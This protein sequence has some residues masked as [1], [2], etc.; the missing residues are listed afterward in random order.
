MSCLSWRYGKGRFAAEVEGNG[1][2]EKSTTESMP[3]RSAMNASLRND[4]SLAYYKIVGSLSNMLAKAAHT[5]DRA[6]FEE[7]FELKFE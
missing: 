3:G 4:P 7:K 2:H 5:Y 1:N 6:T